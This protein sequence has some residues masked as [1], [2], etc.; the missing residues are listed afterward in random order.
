[1]ASAPKIRMDKTKPYGE[2]HG[3]RGPNDPLANVHFTQDG[4]PF[5]AQGLLVY[6]AIN[7]EKVKKAVD[8]KLK[9]MS[10][11]AAP[12]AESEAD[13][14]DV[15]DGEDDGDSEGS[16]DAVPAASVTP[17]D[18]NIESWLRGEANYAWGKITKAVRER[19]HQNISKQ[20]EMV[21]FLILDEKVIPEDEVASDLLALL[22]PKQ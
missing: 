15:D 1:M 6:D 11:K 22:P 4:M 2:V 19:Y 20:A 7:D 5:D 18:V 14:E 16:T 10:A 17:G 21:A 12:A 8:A 9:R 3:E 13:G